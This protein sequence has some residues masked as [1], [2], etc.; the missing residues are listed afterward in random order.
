MQFDMEVK[1][2]STHS[3]PLIGAPKNGEKLPPPPLIETC[4]TGTPPLPV[5]E[6]EAMS[7]S[8]IDFDYSS[9]SEDDEAFIRR[10][11]PRQSKKQKR[12]QKHQE[13]KE[14]RAVLSEMK[15]PLASTSGPLMREQQK[16]RIK[17]PKKFQQMK[18]ETITISTNVNVDIK[19]DTNVT[20][21]KKMSIDSK[22]ATEPPIRKSTRIHTDASSYAEGLTPKRARVS[23]HSSGLNSTRSLENKMQTEN[24]GKLK[25]DHR[26]MEIEPKTGPTKVFIAPQKMEN[27]KEIVSP[28]NVSSV[29]VQLKANSS[30]VKADLQRVIVGITPKETRKRRL[31]KRLMSPDIAELPPLLFRI[32]PSSDSLYNMSDEEPPDLDPMMTPPKKTPRLT[33]HTIG[34]GKENQRMGETLE[35]ATRTGTKTI[36]IAVSAVN[37]WDK[38]NGNDETIKQPAEPTRKRV[39]RTR[40]SSKDSNVRGAHVNDLGSCTPKARTPNL[41]SRIPA[42]K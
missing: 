1:K 21:T 29:Q 27:L 19:S 40:A 11:P 18:E 41:R 3:I 28:M 23:E 10:A 24:Q 30:T 6:P 33:K 25:L 15:N 12:A 16:I 32:S 35:S 34:N 4:A 8:S 20:I 37:G 39:L 2:E 38:S 13:V 36:T 14:D 9:T 7:P 22:N 31:P 26:E 17:F 5:L 42:K